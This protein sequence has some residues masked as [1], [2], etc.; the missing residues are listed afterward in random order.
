MRAINTNFTDLKYISPKWAT[1]YKDASDLLAVRKNDISVRIS[2]I[3]V[4]TLN[5][6]HQA[7]LMVTSNISNQATEYPA[8]HGT[9]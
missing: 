8:E 5:F 9:R 3:W 4:V 1:N 2:V 6:D 7:T